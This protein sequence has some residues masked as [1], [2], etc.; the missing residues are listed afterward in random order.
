M[1][2]AVGLLREMIQSNRR[3]AAVMWVVAVGFAVLALWSP[4]DSAAIAWLGTAVFGLFGL[5]YW[6]QALRWARELRRLD[7]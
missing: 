2:A 6:A 7:V 5:A 1:N 3:I 4:S